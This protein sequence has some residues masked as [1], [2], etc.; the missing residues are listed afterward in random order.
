MRT[1]K[2]TVSDIRGDKRERAVDTK[3]TEVVEAVSGTSLIES[4]LIV[5]SVPVTHLPQDHVWQ[6]CCRHDLGT[7]QSG[8]K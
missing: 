1:M 5:I 7:T 8:I 3:N 4:N 2:R 6:K